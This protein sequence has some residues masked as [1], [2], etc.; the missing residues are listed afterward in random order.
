MAYEVVQE[1]KELLLDVWEW[2]ADGARPPIE[3]CAI[4]QIGLI[5]WFMTAYTTLCDSFRKSSRAMDDYVGI[6][7]TAVIWTEVQMLTR[8]AGSVYRR[9][10]SSTRE[11]SLVKGSVGN[12]TDPRGSNGCLGALRDLADGHP[13]P[14]GDLARFQLPFCLCALAL[15]LRWVRIAD[16]V[17]L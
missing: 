14:L 6:D 10:F 16:D 13:D 2:K 8:A 1:L 17:G 5:A 9:D 11:C 4:V 15:P 3:W 12:W 7:V